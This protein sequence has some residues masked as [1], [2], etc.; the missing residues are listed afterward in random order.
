[1]IPI[2]I[3]L[4]LSGKAEKSL[5]ASLFAH[6]MPSSPR[7]SK[8][9]QQG[10]RLFSPPCLLPAASYELLPQIASI[11]FSLTSRWGASLKYFLAS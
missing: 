4:L 5:P 10:G 8:R 11:S 9:E 3:Y 6:I 7:G 1:M 2:S